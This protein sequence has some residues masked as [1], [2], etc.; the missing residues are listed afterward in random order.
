MNMS[1]QHQ[2]TENV[3]LLQKAVVIRQ[4]G[5]TIEALLLQRSETAI[6]RPN[7]WDLPGGNSEWPI[8]NQFSA[9]NLHL[10]D[11]SREI[12]EETSLK[13][14]EKIFDLS[15]LVHF[16]TYFDSDKQ[17][18]TVI[19]GWIVD[20]SLINQSEIKISDEHQNYIWVSEA[21]L[22]NYDF[23]GDRGAFVLDM[24]QKSFAKFKNHS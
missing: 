13:V 9:A 18:F 8:A 21:N 3:K 5:S 10:I 6:S 22:P 2:L 16:S 20:F 15:Q 7:C 4:S 23:G 19:C 11:L 24:I 14:D 12:F 17:V 1:F